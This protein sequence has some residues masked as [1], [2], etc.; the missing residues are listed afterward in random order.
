MHYRCVHRNVCACDM[1]I[2]IYMRCINMSYVILRV[3]VYM[4]IYVYIYIYI[5]YLCVLC[6]Y[7]C[8]EREREMGVINS[9]TIGLMSKDHF[10]R[11]CQY[12]L[13][14]ASKN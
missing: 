12:P 13:D 10:N 4:I 1:Y 2:Y 14:T 9:G 8:I 11:S 3:Y 7:I 6:G 5:Q